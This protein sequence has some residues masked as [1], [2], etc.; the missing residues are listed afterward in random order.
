MIDNEKFTAIFR[1]HNKAVT[2]YCF[3]K[4]NNKSDVEDTVTEVF[5]L[6]CKKWDSLDFTKPILPWLYRVADNC[7]KR[8]NVSDSQR[9]NDFPDESYEIDLPEE[10][11]TDGE[12]Y[13]RL[14]KE[15]ETEQLRLL[16]R[17]VTD[18]LTE[19]EN[20][21]FYLRYIEKSTIKSI[22]KKIGMPY[23]TIRLKIIT[24]KNKIKRIVKRA[25]KV[26]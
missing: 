17:D 5:L 25:E 16:L 18:D 19:I 11:T 22:S 7:I 20:R 21:I 3:V 6:L 13:D 4:L 10:L 8:S 1:Q 2:K 23:S 24:I 9:K 26:R 15:C 12:I 14:D